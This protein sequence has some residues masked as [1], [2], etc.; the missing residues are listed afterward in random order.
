MSLNVKTNRTTYYF[1]G[2]HQDFTPI[3][4]LSGVYVITTV[5]AVGMHDVIDAGESGSLLD[6][7][8][9]HQGH[10]APAQTERAV[11]FNPLLRRSR[12]NGGRGRYQGPLQP[13]MRRPVTLQ[14]SLSEPC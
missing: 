9:S 11:R 10:L 14:G 2:P 8:A 6:R 5:N 1:D 3:R 4:R 7:L 12:A 13:A